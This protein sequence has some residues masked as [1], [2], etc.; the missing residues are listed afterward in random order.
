MY[1]IRFFEDDEL[2]FED[3]GSKEHIDLDFIYIAYKSKEIIKSYLGDYEYKCDFKSRRRNLDI[4]MHT[5]INEHALYSLNKLL[6]EIMK[7]SIEDIFNYNQAN[8]YI[9]GEDKVISCEMVILH[10]KKSFKLEVGCINQ[11]LN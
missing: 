10:H 9:N 6:D 7:G 2:L 3:K 1:V 4:D 11:I 5:R 8:I